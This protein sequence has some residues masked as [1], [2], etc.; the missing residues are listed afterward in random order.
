MFHLILDLLSL[1]PHGIQ[2]AFVVDVGRACVSELAV[3]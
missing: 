2:G 3:K 1:L